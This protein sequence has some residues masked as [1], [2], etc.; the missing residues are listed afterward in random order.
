MQPLAPQAA[1]KLFTESMELIESPNG[2]YD[3]GSGNMVD[4]PL[5][6]YYALH[7]DLDPTLRSDYAQDWSG[8]NTDIENVLFPA[9]QPF[10]IKAYGAYHGYIA[11][12]QTI[13]ITDGFLSPYIFFQ[14]EPAQPGGGV[15]E[16]E[17]TTGNAPTN[18][19]SSFDS[20]T[21]IPFIN[22]IKNNLIFPYPS[23]EI[24]TM[25]P[26]Q[27]C[28]GTSLGR[29]SGGNRVTFNNGSISITAT[30]K[31]G[32]DSVSFDVAYNLN[33]ITLQSFTF[34]PS[35]G[36]YNDRNEIVVQWGSG[37]RVDLDP[38]KEHTFRIKTD[39]VL[40]LEFFEVKIGG[41]SNGLDEAFSDVNITTIIEGQE[42]EIT[43]PAQWYVNHDI[44]NKFGPNSPINIS[45]WSSLKFK[46]DIYVNP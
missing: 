14:V 34:D 24:S 5:N 32:G 25:D 27:V 20:S 9:P 44:D 23:T 21:L 18:V 35:P 43:I 36:S 31:D 45:V 41:S 3:D 10:K 4:Y 28:G 11:D 8:M 37:A 19:I 17:W 38:D 29:G 12:G 2:Q 26:N 42:Y 39:Q 30:P 40:P 7:A 6:F 1:T 22:M 16:I 13:S 46:I 33:P 15:P